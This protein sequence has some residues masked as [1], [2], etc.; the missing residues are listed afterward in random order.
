MIVKTYEI[1]YSNIFIY[2]L[3]Y[4]CIQVRTKRVINGGKVIKGGLQDR[5]R[6]CNYKIRC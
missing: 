2:V 1:N 4:F 5:L 3:G 6:S